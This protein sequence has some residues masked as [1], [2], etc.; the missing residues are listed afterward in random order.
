M[1]DAPRFRV[2][3]SK[4][5]TAHHDYHGAR[6]V[7]LV[8]YAAEWWLMRRT[9]AVRRWVPARHG[10]RL[11]VFGSGASRPTVPPD[12]MQHSARWND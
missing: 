4:P 7:D 3:E 2:R 10:E 11:R 6:L 12:E 9:G 5:D 8:L 1:T